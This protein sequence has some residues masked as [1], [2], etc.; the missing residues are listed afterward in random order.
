MIL[1]IAQRPIQDSR[2]GRHD[3]ARGDDLFDVDVGDVALGVG[4]S[5]GGGGGGGGGEWGG[6]GGVG[7]RGCGGGILLDVQG[8]GGEGD[9]AAYE[10]GDTLL[11]LGRGGVRI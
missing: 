7:S 10:P 3:S 5:G 1:V 6:G 2:L 4:G 9:D 11:F 8:D